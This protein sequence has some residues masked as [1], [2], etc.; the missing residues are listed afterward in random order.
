MALNFVSPGALGSDAIT[1]ELMRRALLARQ[2]QEDEFKRQQAEQQAKHQAAQLAFQQQQEA[3]IAEQQQQA[4]DDRATA[5]RREQDKAGVR[6]M[7]AE[8]AQNPLTPESARSLELM[9]YRE[10]VAVPGVVAQALQ[11]PKRTVVETTDAKGNPIRKS[12]SE[13]DLE[14]GVPQ[15]VKPEKPE[16]QEPLVAIMGPDN[17]PVLVP[18]SQAI[19]KRP[20]STREQGRPVTSGDAGRIADLDQSLNDLATLTST[21][22]ET[23]TSTGPTAQIGAAIPNAIT[24]ITGIG[25]D[26]KKR[27]GVIDRVKQVIG[28]ALEG[29]VLRKE[30]EAKYEKILPTI[31]DPPEVAS[32]KLEGLRKALVQKRETFLGDLEGSGFEVSRFP[33]TPAQTTKPTAR[34]LIDKYS[35]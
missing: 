13:S 33:R 25:T 4:I 9:G 31:S 3:R 26:A 35:R 5:A 20:A 24:T 21:L 30:D 14:A 7:I 23:S 12:V 17:Q 28:K 6:Q 10:G 22:K 11:P 29:G 8:S 15:Y 32:A 34:E 19:G 18:R 1:Q 2:Q 27:Q 16:V